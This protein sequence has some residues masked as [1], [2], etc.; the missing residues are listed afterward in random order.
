MTNFH[1]G[2]RVVCIKRGLWLSTPSLFP[3]NDQSGAPQY[4][5][6]YTIANICDVGQ[7]DLY[8]V[9]KEAPSWMYNATRFRPVAH[10]TTDISAF[11]RLQTPKKV[12]TV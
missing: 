7:P 5:E 9:L 3:M 10:R 6:I 2:Q 12:E 4:G 11:Q 8:L 1:P